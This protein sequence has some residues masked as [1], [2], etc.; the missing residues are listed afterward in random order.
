MGHTQTNKIELSINEIAR[1]TGFS[2]GAVRNWSIKP[3]VGQVYDENFVNEENVK[4]NL[5]KRYSKE[6][7]KTMLGTDIENIT[8]KK[9]VRVT[10]DYIDV[11][12]LEEG[13]SYILRHYHYEKELTF[14][15][16]IEV[17]DDELYIFK[18]LKDKYEVFTREEL[19]SSKLHIE[20]VEQ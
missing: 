17:N 6:Q 15:K 20:E 13:V 2:N 11:D 3:I 4:N 19:D 14:I 18:S 7:L 16:T 8:I 9:G 1:K 10:K 5:L 12:E